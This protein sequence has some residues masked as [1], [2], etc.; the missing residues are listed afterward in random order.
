MKSKIIKYYGVIY[1]VKS[2][3]KGYG[4]FYIGQTSRNLLSRIV[5]HA[6]ANRKEALDKDI[7]KYGINKFTWSVL[8]RAKHGHDLD[9][10]EIYWIKRENA[11]SWGYNVD[12]G[13]RNATNF[14]PSL[15]T[16]K[17]IKIDETN[18]INI[19]LYQN[20][21]NRD[22]MMLKGFINENGEESYIVDENII[23]QRTEMQ[24]PYLDIIELL[25]K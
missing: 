17:Y 8:H 10:A 19:S 23:L 24:F 1:R 22:V 18:F 11:I 2:R 14:P 7:T 9:N 4:K 5:E 12:S 25:I 6:Y 3:I 16:S 15:I 21:N 20:K 13:G